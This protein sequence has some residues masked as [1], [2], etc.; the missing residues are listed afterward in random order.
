MKL[1]TDFSPLV[2][3]WVAERIPGVEDFGPCQAL[4]VTD[5][6]DNLIG[7]VVFHD[8][9]PQWANI[10]VSF[11]GERADWLT[12]RLITAILSYAFD[13]LDCARITSLTPK[14]N[15]RARQFL[16]KFGFRHEGTIRKG[17]GTDDSIISG[18]LK[19]EWQ[20]H[21]F[22]RGKISRPSASRPRSDATGQRSGR[23]EHRDGD[24][25]TAFEHDRD[26]RAERLYVLRR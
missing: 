12:A 10:Q 2:A 17:F 13:Q 22:N 6:D 3:K 19:T 14:R 5:E 7:G 18:L 1:V 15:R 9:Q 25:A 4:G 23:G 26:S 24:G 8:F 20:E 11:A 21:H 16:M